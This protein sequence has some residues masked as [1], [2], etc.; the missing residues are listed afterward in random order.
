[1]GLSPLFQGV[2]G[3]MYCKLITKGGFLSQCAVLEYIAI[4]LGFPV[5]A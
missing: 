3:K 2:T 5:S 1:M 4:F